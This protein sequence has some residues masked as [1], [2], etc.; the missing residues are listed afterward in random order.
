MIF[1]SRDI[2]DKYRI[3]L[4]K[5]AKEQIAKAASNSHLS[6]SI[7]IRTQYDVLRRLRAYWVPR[8]LMHQERV[9]KLR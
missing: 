7:F 1:V 2:Q 9:R 4:T 8:Y 5:E 6:H 3:H